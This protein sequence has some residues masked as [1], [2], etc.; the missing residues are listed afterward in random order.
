MIWPF[1]R[2]P[3]QPSF[4][5]SIVKS[6]KDDADGWTLEEAGTHFVECSRYDSGA[7]EYGGWNNKKWKREV[8]ILKL[9]HNNK[10]VALC[11]YDATD[12]TGWVIIEPKHILT[13]GGDSDRLS[14]AVEE[15]R[16]RHMAEG[17]KLQ[18]P[19]QDALEEAF[20]ELEKP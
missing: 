1:K 10:T 3:K 9:S 6:L 8:T 15:W 14:D 4:V 5:D 11:D 13:S 18:T 17:L 20:A 16:K 19:E 2:K 7:K 12:Y